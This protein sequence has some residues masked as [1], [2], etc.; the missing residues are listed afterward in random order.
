MLD[1]TGL[2]CPLP[3]LKARK[4]LSTLAAGEVLAVTVTDPSSP[5]DFR[6]FCEAQGHGFLD[7]REETD[8]IFRIRLRKT[9]G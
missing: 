1:A 3:V 7:C 2:R 9:P 6:A 8:G 5:A 4:A